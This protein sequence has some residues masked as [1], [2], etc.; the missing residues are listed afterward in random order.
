MVNTDGPKPS[1]RAWLIAAVATVVVSA[2]L[3]FHHLGAQACR[4]ATHRGILERTWCSFLEGHA[5]CYVS[6]ANTGL[7]VQDMVERGNILFPLMNGQVPMRKPPLIVWLTA[8]YLGIMGREL[9]TPFGMRVQAATAVVLSVALV[10]GFGWKLLGPRAGVLAGLL[11]AGWYQF[12]ARARLARTDT[13][14]AFFDTLA[15]FAL[16]GWL[17]FEH[18]PARSREARR[19]SAYHYLFALSLGLAVLTKGPVGVALPGLAILIWIAVRRRWRTLYR[20][21][22]P[23]PLLAGAT[24][25][26]SWYAACA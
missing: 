18:A 26:M 6:E 11:L 4:P 2:I 1:S 20:L 16:I 14:L 19:R 3:N 5:I 23:G 9:V 15:M 25:A 8:G 22:A 17:K 13:A 10:I 21:C 7:V 24:T 12:V